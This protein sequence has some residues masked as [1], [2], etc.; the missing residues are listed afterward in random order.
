MM[1]LSAPF[2][3]Y[4]PRRGE[5][6]WAPSLLAAT[7][8][9]ALLCIGLAMEMLDGALRGFG[10][11]VAS[12]AVHGGFL[13]IG[14]IVAVGERRAWRG[15]VFRLAAVLLLASVASRFTAWGGLLYLLVPVLVLHEGRQLPVLR[16]IGLTL[17]AGLK[18]IALGLAAGT[19]LGAHLLISAS[20]TS[21]YSIRVA[22]LGQYLLAAAYD[23]GANALTAEWLFRG[24]LFSRWWQRW[25]FW[26][27][28]TLST[29]LA[30]ARYLLDPS[31]PA[32]LEARAGAVFYTSLLGFSACALRAR[33]GSLLPGYLATTAFFAAYRMLAR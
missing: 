6:L 7:A 26:P 17:T 29:A 14:W 22:I 33:S 31:L 9:T 15:P 32:A 13:A 21:G 23:I 2:D 1:L 4:S 12:A 11:G 28:A 8:A 10:L 30:V 24:A 27:A 19:F 20:L 16:G 5:T 25:E 3:P 18:P